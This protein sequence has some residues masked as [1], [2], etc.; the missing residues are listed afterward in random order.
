[1]EILEVNGSVEKHILLLRL[2]EAL[3]NA[4]EFGEKA[5]FE[6]NTPQR[7][8][9][10][11]TGALLSR[12]GIG[13]KAQFQLSFSMLGRYW[14][15]TVNQIMGQ[16]LDAIEELKLE[17]E[18]DGRNQFGSAYAPEDVYRFFADL[19]QIIS[20]AGIG[21]MVI[22]PCFDGG[23][24]E[25]YLSAAPSG[26]AVR[27]LADRYTSDVAT[28]VSKYRV[29]Y[30]SA[31]EIRSSK[32]VHDRLVLIDEDSAWI[33]GGPVKDAGKKATYLI[34]LASAI[35]SAKRAFYQEIWGR[36]IVVA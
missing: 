7:R 23:A 27:V 19:K 14:K 32:E 30:K 13:R 36:A 3:E 1:M 21:L 33:M 15:N 28:D 24:F 9:L 34:P 17:L 5:I 16:V 29:Q 35:A 20:T 4:P 25:A 22:D 12:L 8:W 10:A 31:L 2:S 26:I 6:V 11:S 18:L